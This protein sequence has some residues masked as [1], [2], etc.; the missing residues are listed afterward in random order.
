VSLNFASEEQPTPKM[1]VRVY[2]AQLTNQA[3]NGKGPPGQCRSKKEKEIVYVQ[4]NVRV[5]SGSGSLRMRI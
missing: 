1:V 5:G 2:L 4:R 3:F